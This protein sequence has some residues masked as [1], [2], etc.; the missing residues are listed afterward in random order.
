M[1]KSSSLLFAL[2][3]Y[4]FCSSLSDAS[5]RSA[6]AAAATVL[7]LSSAASSTTSFVYPPLFLVSPSR[8]ALILERRLQFYTILSIPTGRLSSPMSRWCCPLSRSSM[9][10]TPPNRK[11]PLLRTNRVC[12]DSTRNT[13]HYPGRRTNQTEHHAYSQ[14]ANSSTSGNV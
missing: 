6:F 2:T 5:P 12:S 14:H 7:R 4:F 13:N 11:L 8:R 9:M 10:V 3:Q 1:R